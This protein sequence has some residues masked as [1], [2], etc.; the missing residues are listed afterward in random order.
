MTGPE[1]EPGPFSATVDVT[2]VI[3]FSDR[4]LRVAIVLKKVKPSIIGV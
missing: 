1:S 2:H 3:A 4:R